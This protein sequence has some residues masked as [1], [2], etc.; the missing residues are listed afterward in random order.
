MLTTT[1]WLTSS[2]AYDLKT[3]EHVATRV[4]K[5]ISWNSVECALPSRENRTKSDISIDCSLPIKYKGGVARS[6]DVYI[7]C[8]NFRNCVK[9]FGPKLSTLL[10]KSWMIDILFNRTGGLLWK[11]MNNGN[12][13]TFFHCSIDVFFV[14]VLFFF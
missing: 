11:R 3:R 4:T 2:N 14:C 6:K 10:T 9:L 13:I 12:A 5:S 7:E 1:R 8:I